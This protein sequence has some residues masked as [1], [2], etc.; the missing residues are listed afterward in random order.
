MKKVFILSLLWFAF[1][2]SLLAQ[3]KTVEKVLAV[4]ANRKIDLKLTFGDNIKITAWDKKEASVK[5]DYEINGGKLNDALNLDFESDNKSA[6][7]KVDLDEELI[8]KGKSED[9]PGSNGNHSM[10]ISGDDGDR[11]Y[12]CTKI[13]YEI[14]VPRDADLTVE[15]INGNIELRGLTGPVHAKSISGFVDMN[16]SEKKGATVLL[17][18][19]TGEVYSDLGIDFPNGREEAPMVGYELKGNVNGGGSLINLESISNDIYFRKQE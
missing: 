12:T 2:T 7:V 9:C 8:K 3:T 13:N 6:R 19:I 11:S 4:P 15:T 18:T 17:E 14:F 5:I 1:T 16:W 10:Q